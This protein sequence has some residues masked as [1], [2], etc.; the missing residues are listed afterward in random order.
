MDSYRTLQFF[1]DLR[2]SLKTKPT[3]RSFG[4]ELSNLRTS[5]NNKIERV[6]DE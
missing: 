6:L 4:S 1:D 2:L 5:I 3:E